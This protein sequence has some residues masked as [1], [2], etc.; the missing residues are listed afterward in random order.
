[1]IKEFNCPICGN[2]DPKKA[3]EYEGGLGYEAVICKCCASYADSNDWHLSDEW[4]SAQA[5]EL[6]PKNEPELLAALSIKAENLWQ[7]LAAV[8]LQAAAGFAPNP[9]VLNNVL[10]QNRI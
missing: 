8:K 7:T 9:D 2:N 5:G 6:L 10:I 3:H 1:M 4:S